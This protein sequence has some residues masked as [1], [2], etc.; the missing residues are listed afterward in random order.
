MLYTYSTSG[1]ELPHFKC[2]VA[3]C[4]CWLLYVGQWGYKEIGEQWE[5]MGTGLGRG[6]R[7]AGRTQRAE[8]LSEEAGGVRLQRWEV[9]REMSKATADETS[10]LCQESAQPGWWGNI[11]EES[12]WKVLEEFQLWSGRNHPNHKKHSEGRKTSCEY[13]EPKHVFGLWT[14]THS[15]HSWTNIYWIPT[16]CQRLWISVE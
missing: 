15:F 11:G 4:G 2:W 1:F 7:R 16:M 10:L 6:V 3:L 12:E 8:V 14:L 13:K 5:A 9:E